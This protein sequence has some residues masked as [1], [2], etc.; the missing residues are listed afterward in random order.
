MITVGIANEGQT[1]I[2]ADVLK[3]WE[4]KNITFFSD[5]VYFKVDNTFYSM[6]RIDFNNI[7]KK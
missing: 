6:K 4:P 5:I 7:Y 1:N 2:S 3:T